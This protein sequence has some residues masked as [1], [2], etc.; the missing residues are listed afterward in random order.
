MT[1]RKPPKKSAA[2]KTSKQKF[3]T[4]DDSPIKPSQ[5]NHQAIM[6]LVTKLPPEQRKKFLDTFNTLYIEE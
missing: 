5:L 1:N 3:I 4:V 6:R 2:G